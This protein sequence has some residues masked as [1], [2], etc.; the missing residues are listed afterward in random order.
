M[1]YNI[2]FD[3]S[4]LAPIWMLVVVCLAIFIASSLKK[5]S[6]SNY[7][8]VF[9][10]KLNELEKEAKKSLDEIYLLSQ[11]KSPAKLFDLKEKKYLNLFKNKGIVF[12][13]YEND[14]LIFWSDHSPAVENYRK[15][16]CLDNQLAQLS[17]GWYEVIRHSEN[18]KSTKHFIAL[19]LLK[20]EFQY[21]N[22]YLTNVFPKW[23][24]MPNN[25]GLKEFTSS[26]SSVIKNL[27]NSNL[28]E[29]EIDH[30]QVVF[31]LID[32]VLISLYI[33]FF[34][35]LIKCFRNACFR[36]N[37]IISP[38]L[39]LI[40]FS[41]LILV[42]RF[43]MIISQWPAVLYQTPLYD[44][45]V[46]GN[47]NSFW[48]GYLGDILLNAFF[49]F[50]LS[51]VFIRRYTFNK[52]TKKSFITHATVAV[53]FLLAFAY[54]IN[55]TI[56]SL[57]QNSSVSF[58]INNLFSLNVYSYLGFFAIGILF[59]AFYLFVDKLISE[60]IR[61]KPHRK[62][63]FIILLLSLILITTISF[64]TEDFDA[65]KFYW[66]FAIIL[67]AYFLKLG[68]RSYSFSYGLFF[69]IC[70]SISSTNLFLKEDTLKEIG[71]RKVYA[72][73]LSN[74]RDDVAENLFVDVSKKL[75]IDTK[76]SNLIFSPP[77]KS[78]DL[79]QRIRQVYLSGY[80]ERFDAVISVVDSACYPLIKTINPIH[81]NNTYFDLQIENKGIKTTCSNLFFI[82]NLK[83]R[84][85]YI[86]KI[87]ITAPN[88]S[89]RK[90][91][92]IYLEM[93][94]KLETE[95]IGFPELLLDK[96]VKTNSQLNSYSYAVYKNNK[97]T[98]RSGKY[99]YSN[100]FVWKEKTAK[101]Y[102]EINE[103]NFHHLI[104]YSSETKVVLSVPQNSF[105]N[106][107]T[108]NS[109]FFSFFSLTLLIFL[110]IRETIASKASMN[111]SLN[112]RIQLLLVMV[113][114][115]SLFAFGIAT[116]WFVK[117]QFEMQN[118]ETL[119][120]R[121]KSVLIELQSKFGDLDEL[122]EGYKEYC[123]YTLKKLA[124]FFLTDI[125]LYDLKGNLY[126]SSQPRM[127]EE[128]IISKKMN[129]I[130]FSGF[131]S[132]SI[133]GLA[134][135]E[136]IGNL[137]YHSSYQP[138]Y[139][140]NGKLMAYLNLP[141]FAK[142]GEQEKEIS[143]YVTS[144]INIYVILFAIST[145][146]ALLISNL[147]TKPL[148]LI[149][150][151]F[152]K[153][154]FGKIN[155]P[156]KWKEKDEIGNLVSEYNKMIAKLEESAVKLAKSE[157]ESAWREMA[158]QVAHEIKNPLTP[159]KLSVQHLQRTLE[160]N[161]A[162]D[163]K[164]RVKSLCLMLIEQI[165]TLSNIAS[166]FSTF[167]KMP[168]SVLEKINLSHLINSIV[169]LFKET[170]NCEITFTDK[171]TNQPAVNADKSQCNRI[172]T[173]LIKNAVQ[174]IPSDKLGI[175]E[176]IIS[177]EKKNLIIA[178]KDNGTGISEEAMKNIFVPNF[179]TKTEGMGLGLAM[180]K[181][182]IE[183]FNGKIW[184]TTTQNIGTTFYISLPII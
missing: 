113:V 39:L 67:A 5:Y 75:A 122:N 146:A 78:L 168:N 69:I 73:R 81:G 93:E 160:S 154:K 176:I 36:K 179:S 137:P 50:Y 145:L 156:I 169:Q 173:N 132:N 149:Q 123:S 161:E 29:L 32:W 140:K 153:I 143:M 111:T 71:M 25:S 47:A 33:S 34:F 103:N 163:L 56:I 110:F 72:E 77:V 170:E 125:T 66:P 182:M 8:A 19:I 74:Q 13:V 135:K 102:T 6:G 124:N 99:S 167:A 49:L 115:I 1:R 37:E 3:K 174:A 97:L 130:A 31:T 53:I 43:L 48:F 178:V 10:N 155:E 150:Q 180:V 104:Y 144:L 94:P 64:F 80:W 116:F 183:S 54:Q 76:L 96:N 118:T 52:V 181:N 139:N 17:N 147:V 177:Q 21:Q 28:F 148:R 70:F 136:Q 166:E 162:K 30:Q 35:L 85:R 101:K 142:E 40:I 89:N 79:E 100:K 165:E 60:L 65:L 92:F 11:N 127:F 114:L 134:I 109:Y 138:L 98:A 171:T 14:S 105:Q 131:V 141:F 59:F 57:V 2:L 41:S 128:G 4:R 23:F 62:Y 157:R 82:E 119:N 22:K 55:T 15:E 44:S 90:P 158:K 88:K 45:L 87:Q 7:V 20:N 164:E 51:I 58:R 38:N 18:Q 24:E 83:E 121:T 126:A 95:A 129:P 46:F 106:T 91:A 175:I 108:T 184:F 159:M 172:F 120:Q 61:F 63:L 151:K 133:T 16:V 152:S 107:F 9:Q 12:L 117:N 84:P 42:L 26:N 27:D 68:K 112:A 86:A